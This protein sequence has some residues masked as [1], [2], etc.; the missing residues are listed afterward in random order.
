MA[1]YTRKQKKIKL[2]I[3]TKL[4]FLL[5]I[6]NFCKKLNE[7][8]QNN[9]AASYSF[10]SISS[11]SITI[12]TLSKKNSKFHTS[13]G[14]IVK[15]LIILSNDV[16]P[17]PGPKPQ[18]GICNHNIN[19]N[20]IECSTCK[21]IYH[22]LCSKAQSKDEA[23]NNF[24]WICP[25]I[26][27]QP[28][29]YTEGLEGNESSNSPT[30]FALLNSPK[31]N[32]K[33]K[34]QPK[35]SSK[36][37][38]ARSN[39]K[40]ITLL[41]EL[42]P[43]SSD[44]YIGK[45]WCV[46]C[47]R[48]IE[49]RESYNH[50]SHCNK[51]IHRK[52]QNKMRRLE[53][54]QTHIC[55]SKTCL[56]INTTQLKDK[57][58]PEKIDE[59]RKSPDEFIV[60]NMNTRNLTNKY[61]DLEYICE[62]VMPDIICITESWM[63]ESV[64]ENGFIPTG[65]NI[66]RKDRSKGFKKKYNKTTGGGIAI[67]YKNNINVERKT[68]LTEK[69]EEILWVQP[70]TKDPFLLG[71]LYKPDYSDMLE[72][73]KESE[74]EESILENNIKKAT[75]VSNRLIICGDFNID[76]NS[77]SNPKTKQLTTV[78]ETYQLKQH[79]KKPT[80][81][82]PRSGR[83][84][85]IDHIWATEE[86]PSIIRSGT[87]IGLSDHFA[88]YAIINAIKQPIPDEKIQF[89]SFKNYKQ[90]Q[91]QEDLKMKIEE[92]KNLHEYVSAKD[93]NGATD[94]LIKTLREVID[95]H[96]P[97]KV[98]T[99][100]YMQ[101]KIPWF[102]N[103][104]KEKIAFK[105]QLLED[106]RL[107]GS[108]CFNN[109]IKELSNEIHYLK[110]KFKKK[111]V[112]EKLEESEGNSKSY[113]KLINDLLFRGKP[114][115]T[116]EPDMINQDKA[117]QINKFF[118]TVGTEIQKALKTTIHQRNLNGLI[119][120]E[121]VPETVSSISKIFDQIKIDTATG[122]DEIPAKLLKD[123]K[124]VLVPI[125]TL[126]INL[127]YETYTFPNC[128]KHARIKP[129]YKSEDINE[130]KNYRP[131]SIL[132]TL[133][134]I[135]ERAATN[136]ITKYLEQNNLITHTQHAYRQKHSTQTCLIEVVNHLY[137]ILDNKKTPAIISLDLS[138]AFDSINHDLLLSKLA[139]LKM[140]ES[141]IKWVKSYLS[142]RKQITKFQHF[143]S[144]EEEITSGIPQGSILG[145]LMFV[146]FTNDFS[147]SFDASLKIMSYADDT[148]II[149]N[150]KNMENLKTKIK[151][152]IDTA[153]TWYKDNTMKMNVGK[154]EILII[155]KTS[156]VKNFKIF[157]END[158][159]PVKVT[160]SPWIKVLGVKIDHQLNW[161]SQIN[162]VKKN[163]INAIRQ[164]HRI[165]HL[166]PVK[167]RIQLYNTLVTPH[168]DYSDVVWGGC[169]KTNS[170]RIQIAQ[171][172]AVRSITGNRKRDS[173]SAS[174]NKL[175]FL[176]LDQRRYIHETVFIHKSLI[177]QNPSEINN[178]YL[179]HLSITDNRQSYTG[180]LVPPKHNTTKYTQSPLYRTIQSWNSCPSTFP[181]G[182]IKQHKTKLHKHIIQKTYYKP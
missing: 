65:Y 49:N 180:K 140:S 38:K 33:K 53:N 2:N 10:N 43:I 63:D 11:Y 20:G 75:Q 133:S 105:N 52:C 159:K 148:Q 112:A 12:H 132:P 27:C 87:F 51:S 1:N 164:V 60:I 157:F 172:F 96:A 14:A 78:Y 111:Y 6:L 37:V 89:R 85:I 76:M 113:W 120:F 50:C 31:I 139:D 176:R 165:N 124:V 57:E 41:D 147:K 90:E 61:E 62:K 141:T 119:G 123:A 23:Q 8:H 18:C 40:K 84:S 135:F 145:P 44:D 154:T 22:I 108:K 83:A 146:C 26:G 153:Q 174:F 56:I 54:P 47:Y 144:E 114:K 149:V 151:S 142:N 161:N 175:K 16:H 100:K 55:Q 150:D 116:I 117:N 170:K 73:K 34:S 94:E 77:P 178:Q 143:T 36:N 167:H 152:A 109:R 3:Y 166:L 13:K 134:K 68:Y 17:N 39:P 128:L 69:I 25:K 138:K 28:N 179:Q 156:T 130:P 24:T 45:D 107:Y 181:T 91:Y 92:N 102:N 79:I 95:A 160:A 46:Y 131:I 158:G 173:A 182:N 72:L 15:L 86:A 88:T 168:F 169:G 42:T 9:S 74:N 127:S 67:I 137:E 129:L 155:N 29:Y 125:V 171:N 103:I 177:F 110:R 81:V 122:T 70:K 101:Q 136:Q 32:K 126:L 64:P 162:Y 48:N 121:F 118:A 115:K 82:D 30:R 19:Q 104:L 5:V 21:T 71:L 58:S 35:K 4:I 99:T 163:S 59:V 106:R 7:L 97:T 80:R 93:V 98:I 66:I